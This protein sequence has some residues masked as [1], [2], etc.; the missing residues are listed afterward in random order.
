MTQKRRKKL[1][2]PD[3][4]EK[5]REATKDVDRWPDWERGSPSNLRDEPILVNRKKKNHLPECWKTGSPTNSRPPKTFVVCVNNHKF[6][7]ACVCKNCGIGLEPLLL[8]AVIQEMSK[9]R[10]AKLTDF[11]KKV[12]EA[13]KDI[14]VGAIQD[15]NGKDI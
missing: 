13:A 4:W 1:E 10:K 14:L 12:R 3:F 6:Q 11:S 15:L 7:V 8:S 5:M 9:A 2:H